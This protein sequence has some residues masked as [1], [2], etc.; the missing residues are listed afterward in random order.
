MSSNVSIPQGLGIHPSQTSKFI[1]SSSLAALFPSPLLDPLAL[2]SLLPSQNDSPTNGLPQTSA[3]SDTEA[4]LAAD[5][6]NFELRNTRLH[7]QRPKTM[8]VGL[9]T[10]TRRVSE[11]GSEGSGSVGSVDAFAGGADAD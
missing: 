5:E 7:L 3:A 11:S 2:Y 9:D 10:R 1:M 4:V 6:R 8:P